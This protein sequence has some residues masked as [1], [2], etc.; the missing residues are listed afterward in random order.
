MKVIPQC[1][2]L[3]LVYLLAAVANAADPAALFRMAGPLPQSASPNSFFSMPQ[4][5]L[6]PG[7]GYPG[8]QQ[9][10][11]YKR[12]N[13]PFVAADASLTND[14]RRT[15]GMVLPKSGR[16]PPVQQTR[17]SGGVANAFCQDTDVELS[18]WYSASE[19]SELQET[20]VSGRVI[21]E[22]MP[23]VKVYG[24]FASYDNPEGFYRPNSLYL[25]A[26]S[27]YP[28]IWGTMFSADYMRD[29]RENGDWLTLMFLKGHELGR[30]RQGAIFTYKH[31]LA[32]TLT[33]QLPGDSDT[34]DING[35]PS[36]FY[37]AILEIDDGPVTW[38][39]E[40][41]PHVSFVSRETGVRKHHMLAV[42]G[43]RFDFR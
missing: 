19:L 15:T 1:L 22:V 33:R 31:G 34:P 23:R 5:R 26:G 40:A 16:L 6:P 9:Q 38:Y 18:G 35:V 3:V 39:F 7:V 37:R 13:Q 8:E 25:M 36:V 28:S 42:I 10:P 11:E 17:L 30:T 2:G 4:S 43:L 12:C 24:G 27:Q 41:S 20:R 14:D 29:L 32:A 21:V